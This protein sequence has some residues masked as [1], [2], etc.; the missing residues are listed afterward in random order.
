MKFPM[1]VNDSSFLFFFQVGVQVLN[2]GP[3]PSHGEG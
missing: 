2:V 1:E 3:D